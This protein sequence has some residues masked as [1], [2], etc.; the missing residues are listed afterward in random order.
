MFFVIRQISKMHQKREYVIFRTKRN[1]IV[2]KASCIY[3]HTLSSD[4]ADHIIT[5]AFKIHI[6]IN[7][8]RLKCL[9][10]VP[11]VSYFA[12]LHTAYHGTW[13]VNGKLLCK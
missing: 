12:K 5:K 9:C 13:T 11:V 1:H 10:L 2:G 7:L 8:Q 3:R 4:H 6:N